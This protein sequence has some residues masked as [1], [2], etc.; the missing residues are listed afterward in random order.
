MKTIGD[1]KISQNRWVYDLVI[2][3]VSPK[4][5]AITGRRRHLTAI[6]RSLPDLSN[7]YHVLEPRED[8]PR[9]RK[10][11]ACKFHHYTD[12]HLEI[13]TDDEDV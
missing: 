4:H 5:V 13:S 8:P 1:K 3:I 11:K 7:V 2:E 12:E 6:T 10:M 9:I